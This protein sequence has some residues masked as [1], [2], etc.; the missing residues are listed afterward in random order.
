MVVAGPA[1]VNRHVRL[2]IILFL[3][4]LLF[5]LYYSVSVVLLLFLYSKVLFHTWSGLCLRGQMAVVAQPPCDSENV[6][7]LYKT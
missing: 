4:C 6:N 5:I 3:F 7:V 1:G 2:C